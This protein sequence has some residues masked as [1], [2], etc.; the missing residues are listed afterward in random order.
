MAERIVLAIG[1]NSLIDPSKP[2]KEYNDQSY[3]VKETVKAIVEIVEEGYELVITHGNGPQVGFNLIENLCIRKEQKNHPDLEIDVAVA[4]TQGSIGYIIVR[5]IHNT[6]KAK[7]IKKYAISLI[8]Q[9]VVRDKDPAFK[10]PTKF[11]GKS[12]SK[13]EAEKIVKLTGWTFKEYKKGSYR[14]VVPS[15]K[16]INII[17]REQIEN[18]LSLGYVVVAAGGGGIPVVKR[19]S[20]YIGIDAVID[21]DRASALL[22]NLLKAETFVISTGVDRVY[23]DFGLLTQEPI[24]VLY[25]EEAQDMIKKGMFQKG[26]MLPK[27][28]AACEFL[29]K[30]G[31]KLIITNP[32]NLVPA[33]QGKAGT[34]IKHTGGNK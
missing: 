15:P 16:P 10:N 31:E 7:G 9:M 17:E 2:L 8:T 26:S 25:L 12:Y 24:D 18:L 20:K 21:K 28:E 4:R 23:R 14:R 19:D 29:K 3:I 33:L 6:F 27:I 32:S 13:E 5:E 11:V 34:I 30:G 22:G 1:G